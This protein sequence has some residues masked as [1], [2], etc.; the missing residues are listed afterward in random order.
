MMA[1]FYEEVMEREACISAVEVY[2]SCLSPLYRPSSYA[3]S[4]P[5]EV[6]FAIITGGR[7]N[8]LLTFCERYPT[9]AVTTL[10]HSRS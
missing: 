2:M 1:W 4:I 8:I 5:Q 6:R 9:E 7:P 10:T 3:C